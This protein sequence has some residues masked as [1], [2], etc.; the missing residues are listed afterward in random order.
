MLLIAEMLAGKS[1]DLYP[2]DFLLKGT[3]IPSLLLRIWLLQLVKKTPFLFNIDII[4]FFLGSQ[5]GTHRLVPETSCAFRSWH[6]KLYCLPISHF[7]CHWTRNYTYFLLCFLNWSSSYSYSNLELDS[8]CCAAIKHPE[9][10]AFWI[11][12]TEHKEGCFF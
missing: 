2:L 11:Q 6:R 4:P 9:H 3:V 1:A 10:L 5:G 8:A 7:D 12:N